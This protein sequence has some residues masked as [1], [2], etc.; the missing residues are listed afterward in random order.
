M[1]RSPQYIRGY[2]L[3]EV[4]LVVTLLAVLATMAVPTILRD[5][6]QRRL[7]TSVRT[8]R[9]LLTLVRANAMYDGKRY[10]IR[11]PQEDEIDHFGE[12]RQPIIEREDDPFAE[13]NVFMRVTEPWARGETFLRSVWCAE[14]RLGRPTLEKLREKFV[15]QEEDPWFEALAEDFEEGYPPLIVEPDGTSEWVTFVITN[16]P[17]DTDREDLEVPEQIEV[18]MD[19]LTGLIWLQRPFYDEELDM[20]E[21]HGWPPVLRKDF[22][23]IAALTEQDVLEITETTVR[24]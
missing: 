8:M 24:R 12:Q 10:R 20:F 18:I 19:G 22:I 4:V 2:T 9:A 7:P 11:F 23:R 15:A 1:R 3:V 17:R 14:V 6:E 16:A 13:P 21:E 5:I